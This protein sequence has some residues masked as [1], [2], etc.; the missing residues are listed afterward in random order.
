MTVPAVNVAGRTEKGSGGVV[1]VVLVMAMVTSMISPTPN[2]VAVGSG[3]IAPATDTPACAGRVSKRPK[4]STSATRTT[5]RLETDLLT[6]RDIC[7]PSFAVL[8]A[9]L[10]ER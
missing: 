1:W 2:V 5:Q 10:T 7:I 9:Y 8:F 3:L 4:L 6:I